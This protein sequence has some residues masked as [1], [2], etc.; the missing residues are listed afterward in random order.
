MDFESQKDIKLALNPG[1]E[2][3]PLKQGGVSRAIVVDSNKRF[4]LSWD[5]FNRL[6]ETARAIADRVE[7][8]KS[9]LD[10]G[11]FDGALALFLLDYQIDVIDPITTGGTGLSMN[12]VEYDT[13]VS[14]DALEH[15]ESE[16]R[17]KFLTE[18]TRVTANHCFINFPAPRTADAQRMI[19]E[20]TKNPLVEEH[21]IWE[22]PDSS[23]VAS[24]FQKLGFITEVIEHT[25][26]AQWISQYLLQECAPQIASI[27]SSHL[28]KYHSEE[29]IGIALYDLVIATRRKSEQEPHI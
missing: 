29:P 2:L 16:C 23:E 5:R 1:V 18:L 7:A 27:A 22:L 15:I 28:L 26:L 24:L 8:G 3:K 6:Q 11:G 14:V 10:V 25:S 12:V 4:D 20:L 21:V 17:C 13:V 19:F 9:I